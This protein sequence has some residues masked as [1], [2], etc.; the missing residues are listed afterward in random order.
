MP[1]CFKFYLCLEND[2]VR[3]C[4][5]GCASNRAVQS[6]EEVSGSLYW[7]SSLKLGKT[8]KNIFSV[9]FHLYLKILPTV[10]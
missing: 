6:V 8:T 2:A 7:M 10:E 4:V 3:Y 1:V 9:L 5:G